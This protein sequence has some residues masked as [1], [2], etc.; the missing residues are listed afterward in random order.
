ML[1]LLSLL[2]GCSDISLG[3][4]EQREA[5]IL[6]HPTHIDFGN[7]VSGFESDQKSFTVI[8]TGDDDLIITSPFL[9]SGEDK[10]AI[11]DSGE[12]D[13]VVEAGEL[14]EFHVTYTPETFEH[15]SG[16]IEFLSSDEDEPEI[17][18][19]LEG[20]GDAPVMTVDPVDFDYG[21]ISIG[22]DNEERI[23]ITNDGNLP[24]TIDSVVQMV[25]QPADIILEFGSLPDLP[26]HLD[27]GLSVDFLVSYIPNDVGQD[28]SIITIAGNDPYTPE[29]E[30]IQYGS[31]DVEQ[32]YSQ[33][34]IQ[35]EIQ[36]LDILW[37]I[38]DSGSMNRVQ[39][40]LSGNMQMFMNVFVQS[41]ADYRMSVITTSDP[42]IYQIVDATTPNATL[43]MQQMVSVGV[44]GSGVEMG[45][46]MA[47]QALNDVTSA[48]PGGSFFRNNADLVLIFVSDEPDHSPEPVSYYTS[49]FSGLKPSGMFFPYAVIGD[50]PGGCSMPTMFGNYNVQAG[51]GYWD[52]VDYFGSQWFSLC[53]TDWGNQLQNLANNITG[54][55]SY[56]LHESDPIENTIEVYVNG[57]IET[58]WVY[59]SARN[60]V[61][62]TEGNIPEPGDT[63]E[64]NYALWGC[65]E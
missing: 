21:D 34:H 23:T 60:T 30:A 28:D 5:E 48:G 65:Y 31:G 43:T 57:Q 39:S 53:A 24:L 1:F 9:L 36:V 45:L 38:D 32:Y 44:H 3:K 27:P 47:Y 55:W 64:I 20:F 37:I 18:V 50:M 62:F 2:V 33:R 4:I 22:C 54:Q 16:M 42:M 46:E 25:T 63:I 12:E 19:S 6:V 11:G 41:Q 10:F 58:G 56:E 35:Q 13:I 51:E 14:V 40:N 7:L 26:W 15:N 17:Q 61:E 8:N 59:N 29:I 49:F 52:V